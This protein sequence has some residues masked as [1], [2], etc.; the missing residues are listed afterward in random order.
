MSG[1]K[2]LGFSFY[3][4]LPQQVQ[5]KPE[6]RNITNNFDY[7]GDLVTLRRLT[8]ESNKDYRNRLWDVSVHPGGPLYEGVVNGIARNLG[9]LR[10][11][12]LL[13]DLK[14][15]SGGEPV[16]LS[17]RVDILAN[18]VVLYSDWRPGGTA[19]IDR[20]IRTYQIG[21][22]GYYLDDLAAEI[23]NSDYFSAELIGSVR[24]NTISSTIVRQSS[25]IPIRGEYIRAD[26]L[27]Q[28][29]YTYIVRNSVSF[30][31]KDIFETEVTGEPA[32]KGEYSI[33]YTNGEIQSYM[34]PSGQSFCSYYAA[35]FPMTIDTAPV[36]VF[37][38]QDDDF[39]Y[40]LF[41]KEELDSGE[42]I[43]SLPN[44]EG[45]EIYHQLFKEA[46]VFWGE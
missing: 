34:L 30:L 8:G 7:Q 11:P 21:D 10:V 38:F 18:K 24:T 25:N 45:S 44:T 31:E 12:S 26:K 2:L 41:T 40:E 3:I 6:V 9:I 37:S 4:T 43:N 1:R 5:G 14:S 39:Q 19:V 35:G 22:T 28:L 33:D 29:D 23:N 20:E 15:A 16:A 27:T 32:V 42:L 46:D 17:P 36:Q 13:I